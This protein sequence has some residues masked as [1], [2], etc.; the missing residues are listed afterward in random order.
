MSEELM[1][2]LGV[3]ELPFH[4]ADKRVTDL[5]DLSEKVAVVAGGGG[6]N[7]GQACVNRLAGLGASVAVVDFNGA[8]AEDVARQA[9][10][11]WGVASI[12]KQGDMTKWTDVSDAVKAIADRFG[13]IDIWVNSVGNPTL[14]QRFWEFTPE[15][16]DADLDRNLRSTM[17][18][19]RAVLDVML[20]TKSGRIIN[21]A[22]DAGRVAMPYISVYGSAKAG[23]I[24]FTRCLAKDL[25]DTGVTTVAVAPGMNIS[26]P[27]IEALRQVNIELER[28]VIAGLDRTMLP[29]A[30]LAEEVANVV[31][32]LATEAGSYVHAT[33]VSVSGGMSD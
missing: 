13:K 26:P 14:A 20:P 22:S 10:N 4:I 12:S 33:T 31:G 1:R 5:M 27:L 23:V 18:C 28:S 7:L 6:P 32:F 8:A 21:I 30:A 16:I 3:A 9:G 19:A 29:R 17:Y 24:G 2:R 25:I 15:Q 11:K